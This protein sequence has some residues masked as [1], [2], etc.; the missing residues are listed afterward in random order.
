[1]TPPRTRRRRPAIRHAAV[2]LVFAL[3]CRGGGGPGRVCTDCTPAGALTYALPSPPGA[4]LWTTTTMDK[5]LREAAPP[6]AAGDAI[7]LHAARNE[8]ESFQVVVRAAAG[9]TATLALTPFSGPGAGAVTRRELRRV[10]YVRVAAPSDA[11]SIPSGMIPDP[12]VPASFGSAQPVPGGQNQPFWITIHV[13]ADAPAGDYAATLTVTVAG[14]A[15]QIPVRLHVFGFALPARIGFDGNWNTNF[16]A[17]G[18]SDSLAA[19]E[20]LKTFFFEHRLTPSGVAWPAGLNHDGGIRYDCASGAFVEEANDYHFSRLGPKYVDGTGWNGVG[21]PSFQVMQFVDNATP[22]PTTFCGVARG[23]PYGTDAYNAAW[24]RLLAAIDAYLV[25]HGWA[26]KGYYYVQNEPQEQADYNLAA[27]LANLSKTAA[28]HLRIAVSEE[29]KPEIAENARAGGHGYD[30]WWADLSEFDP[31]YAQVRQAAGEEVWWYFLHGDRPPH[32]NPITIDH[33][34]IESRIPFWAAWKYRV[35]GFAYYSVTGWGSDPYQDPRPQGTAQN[36]D[37]FLLYP[38]RDGGLVSSIRFELLREGAED[39]EYLLLAAGGAAPATP[40]QPAGCDASVA[41]A[42]SSTTAYTRD[43]SALMD[44]RRQLGLY[45]EGKVSG[46]PR[47]QSTLPGA[48]PRAAYYLNFQDPAGEPRTSPLVVN[49]HEWTKV[50]W[51]AY[52]ARKGYGWSGPFIGDPGIMK[53]EYLADA[54]VDELQ[55]S[56]LYDDYGRTDAFSW[57]LESG[58][59]RVT[60][61]VGWYGRTYAKHRAVVEGTVLVDSEATTPAAPY[62]VRSAVVDVQDGALTLEAGQFD[63]YTILNWMSIEPV[64]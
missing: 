29:P 56:V 14:A 13:P 32:F 53:A 23:D 38:P 52:D 42:V 21:F 22:R 26:E 36:G 18:G 40:G 20:A 30:L 61:S 48:H 45:L 1:M 16:G 11:S 6:A 37:G 25:A 9:A 10:E 51:E 63:Q 17:L 64:E 28:P 58:R 31:D 35:K 8:F 60:V 5:V 27:F 50:G 19:V 41:S 39:Y 44:L 47:L 24:S 62:L 54:P 12:L 2:A 49:G 3:A 57:D 4:T 55:R 59:Y 33:A 46:C 43:A 34:G 15:Q 7:A